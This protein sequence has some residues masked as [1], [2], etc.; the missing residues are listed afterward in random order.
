MFYLLQLPIK[1]FLKDTEILT[2]PIDITL[3]DLLKL[4]QKYER[5][6]A[7][8]IKDS[9]PVGIIT[10]RDV[11]KALHEKYSL[12]TPAFHLAKREL[13]KI[14]SKD[15]LFNA[16]NI[17]TENFIRRL[18]V[19]NDKGEFE[20]VITQQDLILHSSAELFKG[21]GKIRDLLEMKDKLIYAEESDT[22]DIAL[23]KMVQHNVGSLP[24]LDASLR[25][26]GIITEKDFLTLDSDNLKTP[27]KEVALKK[28]FTVGIKD[29]IIKGIDLFKKYNIR[30]L[31]VVDD[32]GR[33]LGVLSQRDFV[34]SLTCTY[35]DFLESNLKQA[36]S[37]I[38]LLPEI[39]LELSE[40]DSECRITWMN[41]FAK[42]N[43]GEKYVERDIYTLIDFDDWNR[44]YGLLKRE[45]MIYKE[46]IKGQDGKIYEVT[47]TYLDF[48]IKEGKIKL[49]LRDITYEFIKEENYQREIRF[50][51]SFLDNSLDY[52]FVIDKDGRIR[53]ANTAFKK[54]LG[55]SDE[56]IKNR[57]IFDIVD[58]SEEDLRKN[59]ELLI[60][61][62]VEIKGRRFYRDINQNLIPV[63]I[64]AKAVIL[65]GDFY[66]IINARDI[67][68]G[69][70]YERAL[71]ER[72]LILSSF[73]A[74]ANS[75]NYARTEEELFQ[76]IEK[77]LLEK[78]D[79]F[80]YFE[81][82][83]QTEEIKTTYLAG[84]KEYWNDCLSREAKE[85][86][87]YITGKSFLGKD[88][89]FCSRL[90]R[91]DLPH[92]CIP[93]IF[94]GRV[95]GVLTLIREKPFTE[96][97]LKFL[98]DKVQIFNI[99]LNQMK[100]IKEYREL[101]IRD[102]LLGIYNRRF[103]IEML[104]KEEKKAK[105]TGKPFS[106]IL[107]DLDHFKKI[108]DTY[109]H[110]VGDRILKEFSDLVGSLIRGMDYF[111]R[112]GGEE[113]LIM[114]PEISKDS[115]VLVAERIRKALEKHEI[116]ISEGQTI[117]LTASF[118]VAEYPADAL[119]YEGLIKKADTRLYQAKAEG[120]NRV[121]FK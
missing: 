81:V 11:L 113:F 40:C 112:F 109:G 80:H 39:V 12:D 26:I 57:T 76:V 50:L 73:Y 46:K 55:F 96:E 48:G 100:L 97:E 64:K 25:P 31:V 89:H 103:L 74:F 115:A 71:Q 49:F 44:V 10:E 106:I 121:V 2:P 33:A 7:V 24:I 19:V 20:G 102:P 108:N 6:F 51:K 58:L 5:N 65:N 28:V 56:E 78:V 90:K 41:D 86:R 17:M 34:Q 98:E 79:T 32:E 72:Y 117:K 93:L 85:C 22:L 82:D 120:R 52:I 54:A 27:L 38:S 30:H 104:K 4:F 14:K 18:I 42:K 116:L 91:P 35:A 36:K 3:K 110:F 8:F 114:L 95:Q 70:E 62:G 107:A 83:S 105:R 75:L 66:I 84:K 47:G 60:K 21:E 118:G 87:V 61:K 69:L 1:N 63:E 67:K 37:F 119:N 101:S 29:P 16:F 77:F 23:S 15:T 68:E 94:E 45:K 59:M 88:E 53:F 13:F 99:Y 111:A 43:L 9:K 92:F